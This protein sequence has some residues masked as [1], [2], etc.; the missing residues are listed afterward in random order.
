MGELTCPDDCTNPL[1]GICN[2]FDGTCTCMPGFEGDNCS[3]KKLFLNH[4]ALSSFNQIFILLKPL[5]MTNT[6]SPDKMSIKT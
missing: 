5:T 4:I 6:K 3:G 2:G 1:Q